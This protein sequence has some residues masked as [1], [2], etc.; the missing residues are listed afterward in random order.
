M[1]GSDWELGG[2]STVETRGSA[3][4]ERVKTVYS[5]SE[6]VTCKCVS[7]LLSS[8]IPSTLYGAESSEW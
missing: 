3:F 6:A 2:H 1:R 7:V 4:E 8:V 5:L